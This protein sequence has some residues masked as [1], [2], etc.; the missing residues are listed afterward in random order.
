MPTIHGKE[1]L[2]HVLDTYARAYT[3][4][5][6]SNTSHNYMPQQCVSMDVMSSMIEDSDDGDG[7]YDFQA[8]TL[9]K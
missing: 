3:L 7:V 6:L 2:L 1:C 8:K 4:N 5:V 9:R